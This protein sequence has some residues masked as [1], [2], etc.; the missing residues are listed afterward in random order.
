MPCVLVTG[1]SSGIGLAT[2]RLLSQSGMTVFA[3]VRRLSDREPGE[4]RLTFQEVLLD[5]TKPDSIA[6]AVR[7]IAS[8]TGEAGLF[9]LVNN[10]GVGDISPL[11]YTPARASSRS[12]RSQCL[13]RRCRHAGFSSAPARRPRAN[14]QH[15]IGRRHEHH[16]LRRIALRQQQAIEAVSDALRLELWAS[17]ISVTLIQPA[18]INSGSAERARRA[19]GENHRIAP[20]GRQGGGIR[21][22]FASLPRK[23]SSRRPPARRPRSWQRPCSRPSAPAHRPRGGWLERTANCCDSLDGFLP[24]TLRDA[25]LRHLFL[26]NP[27][28][29]S[30]R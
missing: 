19:D 1:A 16:S 5:V 6:A 24:D 29:G 30:Q 2:A 12:F 15:R 25:L 4:Q 10:A 17:G 22:C 21:E 27:P 8:R 11:E 7:E 9:A 26:G 28:F 14:R 13:R 23:C 3:G 18:S 20:A